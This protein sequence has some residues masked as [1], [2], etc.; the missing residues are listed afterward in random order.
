MTLTSGARYVG[1][2]TNLPVSVG[3]SISLAVPKSI[4]KNTDTH[5][6]ASLNRSNKMHLLGR[7]IRQQKDQYFGEEY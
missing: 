6:Y 2:S 3:W 1:L 5:T 7:H 4:C